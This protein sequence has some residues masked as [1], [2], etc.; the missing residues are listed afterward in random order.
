M[1]HET[2]P[3]RM[4]RLWRQVVVVLGLAALLLGGIWRYRGFSGR[5]LLFW[6]EAVFVLEA[7]FYWALATDDA[8]L[9][10]R[11]GAPR[12]AKPLFNMLILAAERLT[13]D[14][15]AA[16]FLVSLVAGAAL[17][18]LVLLLP[19]CGLDRRSRWL[20]VG[21]LAL[22]PPLIHYSRVAL[23]ESVSILL[24][25]AAWWI[26]VAAGEER[27]DGRRAALRALLAGFLAG[28]AFATNFRLSFLLVLFLLL[29]LVRARREPRR[30]LVR[31]GL[32]GLG[33]AAPVLLCQAWSLW[34]PRHTALPLDAAGIQ[35]YFTQL[36]ELYGFH[37]GNRW[38]PRGLH[39]YLLLLGHTSGWIPLAAAA[40]GA[41]VLL[42]RRRP[43]GNAAP[44]MLIP[45]VPILFFSGYT[46]KALRFVSVS[47]PFLAVLPAFAVERLQRR[48]PAAG[49]IAHVG[50]LLALALSARPLAGAQSCYRQTYQ[51]IASEAPQG[52]VVA[53]MPLAAV[54]YLDGF[55]V[56]PFPEETARLDPLIRGERPAF[57][58]VDSQRYALLRGDAS[59]STTLPPALQQW[60][61]EHAP[62]RTFQHRNP[63]TIMK[64]FNF[65]HVDEIGRT[66]DF[67]R[68]VPAEEAGRVYVYRLDGAAG[69]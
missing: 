69:E 48:S 52:I 18:L 44:A 29:E 42:G 62:L 2:D 15:V 12:H 60:I 54:A 50:L 55:Q 13:G 41:A 7:R 36:R 26:Q 19:V 20:A 68:R 4:E 34:V 32:L 57:L 33:F 59:L 56:M 14:D 37:A 51:S 64:Y 3:T 17:P 43:W 65:E 27:P 49:A 58:V 11:S 35:D 31:L 21:Y 16:P 1:S 30:A 24:F 63:G 25:F 67:L 23:A 46:T 8:A 5:S 66:M 61:D 45:L 38:S 22:A 40:L 9:L 53:T 10:R 6:D 28:S 47:L 39:T